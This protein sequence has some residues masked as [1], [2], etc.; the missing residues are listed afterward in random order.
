MPLKV[1]IALIAACDFIYWIVRLV[2]GFP[3][4]VLCCVLWA[5][6]VVGSL[7]LCVFY[8]FC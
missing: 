7:P 2:L 8:A 3:N 1:Q 4:V 6:A 5:F